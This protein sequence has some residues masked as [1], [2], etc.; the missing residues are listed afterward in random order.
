M[1]IPDKPEE[2]WSEYPEAELN[3]ELVARVQLMADA[4][5]SLRFISEALYREGITNALGA[6]YSA[7]SIKSM[8]D[9]P[10]DFEVQARL[11]GASEETLSLYRQGR[12]TKNEVEIM[13][14]NG[15]A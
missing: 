13:L 3:P 7:S 9:S 5:Y 8:V 14:L 1:G 11:A 10:V 6:P 12:L 15:T 2:R 4:G